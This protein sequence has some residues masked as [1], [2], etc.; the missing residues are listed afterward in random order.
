MHHVL[1]GTRKEG[2]EKRPCRLRGSM[3]REPGSPRER[4]GFLLNGLCIHGV[5]WIGTRLKKGEPRGPKT[6]TGT[7]GSQGSH[8]TGGSY[9]A[10]DV[11][12][13]GPLSIDHRSGYSRSLGPKSMA[14]MVVLNQMPVKTLKDAVFGPKSFRF[15]SFEP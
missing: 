10:Y 7:K 3:D 8:G 15:G 9:Q 4:V 13:F 12:H 14:L 5:Q 1:E 11:R 6:L 2:L